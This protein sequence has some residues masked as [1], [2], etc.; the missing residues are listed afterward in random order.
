MP[1]TSRPVRTNP[2]SSLD[3][4]GSTPARLYL[5][6][7]GLLL[8]LGTVVVTLTVP[9]DVDIDIYAIATFGACLIGSIVL[10]FW[11]LVILAPN[12]PGS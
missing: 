2:S 5:G 4:M 10:M 11:A 3:L 7:G 12:K 8:F 1:R 9:K 6:L